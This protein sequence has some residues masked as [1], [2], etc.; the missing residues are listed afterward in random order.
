MTI[1]FENTPGWR[2][3]SRIASIKWYSQREVRAAWPPISQ[4]GKRRR[5]FLF[6][7]RRHRRADLCPSLPP[8]ICVVVPTTLALIYTKLE[9]FKHLCY[10]N[11]VTDVG[12]L[13]F[14]GCVNTSA[15]IFNVLFL[16]AKTFITES[17]PFCQCFT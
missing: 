8:A 17:F 11:D 7:P 15:L 1:A 6:R 5:R 12:F 16:N 13:L 3:I 9:F 14:S 4:C 10:T 2:R